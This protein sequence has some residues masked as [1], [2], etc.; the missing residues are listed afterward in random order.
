LTAGTGKIGLRLSSHP[1][2]VA[3]AKAVGSAITGTS[4]NLSGAPPCSTAE[5]VSQALGSAVDKILD[6]GETPGQKPSTVLDLT[7]RPHAVLREGLVSREML[8]PFCEEA[9]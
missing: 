4:A 7:S 3:L 1:V 2:A 6:G 8:Q 9:H 5:A